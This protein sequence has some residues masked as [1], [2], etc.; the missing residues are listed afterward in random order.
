MQA[1]LIL[2]LAAYQPPATLDPEVA[3]LVERLVEESDGL[4]L[5]EAQ[6]QALLESA[7]HDPPGG[8]EGR[9]RWLPSLVVR[10]SWSPGRHELIVYVSWPLG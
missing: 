2:V 7:G 9:R 1:V 10:L 5:A 3:A 8:G 6:V 4:P